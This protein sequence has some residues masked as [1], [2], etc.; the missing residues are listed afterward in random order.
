[1]R[2]LWSAPHGPQAEQA[3]SQ[4]LQ[5]FEAKL[6][7]GHPGC[8][9]VQW[10]G[11]DAQKPARA[12]EFAWPSEEARSAPLVYLQDPI[13]EKAV[14]IVQDR[15]GCMWVQESGRGLDFSQR[16]VPSPFPNVRLPSLDA[17]ATVTVLL[18][19]AKTIRPWVFVSNDN[20]FQRS[21]IAL[22]MFLMAFCTVLLATVFIALGFGERLERVV[23]GFSVFAGALLFWLVHNFSIGSMLFDFWPG[24]QHFALLQ[25]IAVSSVVFG[26]GFANIEFLNFQGARRRA[27]QVAVTLSAL[28]FFSSAW[29]QPGYRVGAAMLA[30]LALLT[31]LELTRQLSNSDWS[32]KLF[33]LGFS[34]TIVG[35]GTQAL[36]VILGGATSG[37]WAIYAFPVGA[38]TQSLFWLAAV[39]TQVQTQRRERQAKLVYDASYD[40]LTG[41][42]NR[43]LITARIQ[44]RCE[45]W[46]NTHHATGT[47]APRGALLFLGLDRFK[48][49]ND[50]LGHA[51]GDEMLKEVS[52]RLRVACGTSAQVGRFGGDEFLILTADTPSLSEVQALTQTITQAIAQPMTV[53][54]R[55]LEM[56]CSVGVRMIDAQCHRMEDVLR[57]ADIALH[58]AKQSGGSQM[59]VFEQTMRD[60]LEAR[61]TLEADLAEALRAGQLELFFQ[62][63]VS[64]KDQ[65]HAG[66]EALVR[67]RHPSGTYV[68]PVEF[69]PVA[70]ETGMIKQLGQQVLELA[71]QAIAQWKQQ[72]LW[73]QGWYVS[74]NVSGGQLGDDSLL[75]QLESLQARYGVACE[76]LR[77]ELTETAVIS[78]SEVSDKLFPL[79]RQRGIGLCMDDFGTGYS[80]LSYLSVLPF[81]VLKIDKSFIDDVLT[82]PKQRALVRAVLFMSHELGLMVVAEGI[83]AAEQNTLMTELGCGYGQGYFYAKP[84]PLPLATD[85]LRSHKTA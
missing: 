85:W 33:T 62:P 60:A 42:Y 19:D 55:T 71:M 23:L 36:S 43:A 51:A 1:M 61:L 82:E 17:H 39:V 46:R 20:A 10:H 84:L 28:A 26:I 53:G 5:A 16:A 81:N 47:Q 30:V 77:L 69:V 27:F 58:G 8:T 22:W 79:I 48:N 83:E 52:Q 76:D 4:W 37:H 15:Q 67:W 68:N 35:G 2:E 31:L 75:L 59:R 18:Q 9:A 50:T 6:A 41:L 73:Q 65:A 7:Q 63:I 32:F 72:G 49:I 29:W 40:A 38:F 56:V 80:S 57:D 12:F 78:N 13:T 34:A 3:A 54:G 64:L 66:F 44:A 45:A 25:A 14:F 24:A 70:E 11:L 74:V 21:S